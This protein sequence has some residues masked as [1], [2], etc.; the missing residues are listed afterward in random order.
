MK[1][2]P[3]SQWWDMHGTT[4]E[5]VYGTQHMPQV[6]GFTASTAPNELVLKNTAEMTE[7]MRRLIKGEPIVQPD[8]RM[9]EDG[10]LFQKG[11]MM[12]MET[13]RKN[14]L[15]KSS[16]GLLDQLSADKVRNE[17]QAMMGDPSAIPL[18]VYWARVAEDP[19]KGIFTAAQE[20][21]FPPGLPYAVGK[22]VIS[23]HALRNNESP[24]NY[25]A[26]IWAAIR[27]RIKNTGELFGQKYRRGTNLGESKGY[28]DHFDDLIRMK[29]KLLG[30]TEDEM[31][32][33]L[34]EG[35]A[36]LM[37][38]M[39]ASPIVYGLYSEVTGQNPEQ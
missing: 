7:Y 35:D 38:A 16:K 12:P 24:A 17:A 10:V 11:S 9:P 14:N 5:D 3:R 8:W 39:L 37:S 33:R 6:A 4:L 34:R 36:N 22:D 25:S 18:D 15:V 27:E 21:V 30:I 31:K 1:T 2:H 19:A 28:A 32:K 20:G 26:K 23:A 13:S 29:S